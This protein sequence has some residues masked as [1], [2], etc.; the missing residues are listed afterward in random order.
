MP[1]VKK[2]RTKFHHS[3]KKTSDD[4]LEDLGISFKVP[5]PVPTGNVPLDP[6]N[7]PRLIENPFTGEKMDNE[8]SMSMASS[9]MSSR[10]SA[11]RLGRDGDGNIV[12]KKKRRQA[13]RDFLLNRLNLSKENDQFEQDQK[14]KKE[15]GGTAAT[16]DSLLGSL[17]TQSQMFIENIQKE[18]K[19]RINN[20]AKLTQKDCRNS[21][22]KRANRI[23]KEEIST[24]Q[25]K[26]ENQSPK[27]SLMEQLKMMKSK[28]IDN[29]E[30]QNALLEESAK[31]EKAAQEYF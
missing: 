18:T 20:N 4:D 21:R 31:V 13:R 5:P 2:E 23:I 7:L 11:S 25:K 19:E 14:K 3:V 16:I 9:R 10:S 26:V 27:I 12:S 24:F 28:I 6:K 30:T 22:T 15:T 29:V 8:D 1:K 17:P